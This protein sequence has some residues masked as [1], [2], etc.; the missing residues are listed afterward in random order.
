MTSALLRSSG[1]STT[2]PCEVSNETEL[3]ETL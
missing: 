3:S 2:K 1:L